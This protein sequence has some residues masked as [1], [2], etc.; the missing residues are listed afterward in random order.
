MTHA[1]RAGWDPQFDGDT[2][3]DLTY[4]EVRE[5]NFLKFV[6][7]KACL[8]YPVLSQYS[9]MSFFLR[10]LSRNGKKTF[11]RG[12]INFTVFSHCTEKDI[13]L[14]FAVHCWS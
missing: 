11:K 6:F 1:L 3:F 13:T 7:S 2:H 4:G 8:S 14:K 10:A 12:V 9:K 5:I